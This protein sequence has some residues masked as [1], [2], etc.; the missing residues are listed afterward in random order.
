MWQTRTD[1]QIAVVHVFG[2]QMLNSA[3]HSSK[4]QLCMYPSG[5]GPAYSEALRYSYLQFVFSQCVVEMSRC[6]VSRPSLVDRATV[7]WQSQWETDPGIPILQRRIL[8][9]HHLESSFVH[10]FLHYS[11]CTAGKYF[12]QVFSS[13]F[14][15]FHKDL[16][17]YLFPC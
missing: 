4:I 7:W 2:P 11:P 12:K 5:K 15:V 6:L 14:L 9:T 16:I 1:V 3:T 10:S 17:K 13:I 8:A